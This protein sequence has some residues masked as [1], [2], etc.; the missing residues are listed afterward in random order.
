MK[1]S[2][3]R[4]AALFGCAFLSACSGSA[5]DRGQSGSIP[6]R[7]EIVFYSN[8]TDR[9]IGLGKAEQTLI[10]RYM[11]ENPQI[12]ITVRTIAPNS[13]YQSK[14]KLLQ[15]AHRLPDL[16]VSSSDSTFLDPLVRSGDVQALGP[17]VLDGFG[18]PDDSLAAFTRGDRLYGVPR[19]RSF[20]A[21][22]YN[23]DLFKK[24]GA[25]VPRT[26]EELL[27]AG[28]LFEAKGLVPIAADGRGADT[29]KRLFNTMIERVSG[30]NK[31][32]AEANEGSI[33]FTDSQIQTAAEH[34]QRWVKEGLFGD[35]FLNQDYGSAR[36]L[37]GQGKA[38]MYLQG[39]WEADID[40]D[41][42]F[43]PGIRSSIGIVNI[44]SL[45]GGQGKAE[46]I[47]SWYGEGILVFKDSPVK[48]EALVFLKWM[49]RQDN[50]AALT[51]DDGLSLPIQPAA[52]SDSQAAEG[53]RSDLTRIQMEAIAGAPP[54]WTPN[55][56]NELEAARNVLVEQFVSL[57][58]TPQQFVNELD[59]LGW[60]I[61]TIRRLSQ[62]S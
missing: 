34:L 1:R 30:T 6:E 25:K 14:I 58:L 17:E 37:F 8:R 4:T 60:D 57:R 22:Y 20:L 2:W 12:Q 48:E 24:Y 40:G 28:K 46:D 54:V 53:I 62:I 45:S 10:D 27:S 56:S 31:T 49:F 15:A 47:Y 16:F 38:A 26:E 59:R 13:Q 23:R 50:W 61:T 21:L 32:L 39:N 36:T 3:V 35:D 52:E 7:K 55:Q 42:N 41:E 43:D 51:A 9:T 18:F 19:T 5:I 11:K 29:F 44:P 33:A